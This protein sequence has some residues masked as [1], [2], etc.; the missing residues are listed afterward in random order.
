M[1]PT[2]D[3]KRQLLQLLGALVLGFALGALYDLLRPPRRRLGGLAAALLDL[4]F[5]L[6]A[7]TAAFLYAM[8][9]LDGRLGLWE[10]AAAA[11]GFLLYMP[12]LSP[13][14][15]PL[16]SACFEFL[17]GMIGSC[18]ILCAKVPISAKKNFQK[19][20]KCFIVKR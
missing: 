16:F 11:L 18:K 13:L 10:L 17:C 20:R 4:L 3:P 8:G 1:S 15:Y 7:G 2:L 5:A 9:A 12:L 19:V 14:F 6:L